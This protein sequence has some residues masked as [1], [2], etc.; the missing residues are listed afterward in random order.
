ML[1]GWLGKLLGKDP[2][3][4]EPADSAS[5]AEGRTVY[6]PVPAEAPARGEGGTDA[7]RRE[8]GSPLTLSVYTPASPESPVLHAPGEEAPPD[9]LAARVADRIRSY[10]DFPEPDIIFRDITPIFRDPALVS[11]IV[12]AFARDVEARGADLVAAVE[13]RGFLF[14]V[15]LA[16]E[17]DLPLALIRKQGKLPGDTVSRSYGLEYGEAVVELQRDAVRDGARTYVV[18]DL[19]ATGGTLEAA[20][21]LVRAAGAEVVGMGV[22]VELRALEGR[23]RLENFNVLSILEL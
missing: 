19:L 23:E 16:A 5:P 8:A 1:D 14:G 18:D 2:D 17:L 13:S 12:Q 15:P 7:E 9:G 22:L 11:E 10:P 6:V 20:A 3:P 4:G 21:G